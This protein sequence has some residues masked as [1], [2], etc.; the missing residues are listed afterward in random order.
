MK[1]VLDT[2]V[3]LDWLVFAD[4]GVQPIVRGAEAGVLHLVATEQTRDE[5]R[6]VIARAQFGLDEQARAAAA[7]AHDSRVRLRPRAPACALRC[8]DRDDQKFVDLAIAEAASW[9]V[10]K[11]KALLAL[12]RHAARSHALAIVRPDA[13]SLRDALAAAVG[14]AAAAANL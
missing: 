6:D 5:W 7:A 4:P 10:T 13:P 1:A 9:L 12:A 8:R 14:T 3:W 2:N 11:D